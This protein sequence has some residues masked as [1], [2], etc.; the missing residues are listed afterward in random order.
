MKNSNYEL[1]LLNMLASKIVGNE[2]S[3]IS[4]YLKKRFSN[5]TYFE[6]GLRLICNDF[7]MRHP[8]LPPKDA[9]VEFE[10]IK[11]IA[12][13]KATEWDADNIGSIVFSDFSDFDALKDVENVLWLFYKGNIKLL[14][15]KKQITSVI[16]ENSLDSESKEWLENQIIDQKIILS[17]FATKTNH[18]AVEMCAKNKIPTILF[19]GVDLSYS[20]VENSLKSYLNY[21]FKNG[22]VISEIIP[23]SET[24]GTISDNQRNELIASISSTSVIGELNK[25]SQ[26]LTYMIDANKKDVKLLI[27]ERQ[28]SKN[29]SFIKFHPNLKKLEESLIVK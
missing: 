20:K 8:T 23:W 11:H 25:I 16:G 28:L 26:T 13:I 1:A 7:V 22:L 18:F 14:N 24:I 12:N 21:L 5:V 9:R 10:N 17:S 27:S 15:D 19:L 2:W 29:S 3:T 4:L 6:D